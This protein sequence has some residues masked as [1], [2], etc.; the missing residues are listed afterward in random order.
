MTTAELIRRK[1]R[2]KVKAKRHWTYA[3]MVA[4]L[5]ETNLPVELWNGEL[6]M[7]PAPY[8]DHQRIVGNFFRKLDEFVEQ[9]KLGKV[10]GRPVAVVLTQHRVVQPD[11]VFVGKSRLQIVKKFVDGVPDLVVEVISE[12]SWKRDRIE[13]RALYEQAGLPEYWV[14]DP[15]FEMIEVF[16]PDGVLARGPSGDSKLLDGFGISFTE[17]CGHSANSAAKLN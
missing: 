9:E 15:N 7:S 5:P 16:A 12:D 13:K 11:V 10:L 6:V 17:L 3:E 1:S 2:G 8:P 4:E 14:V